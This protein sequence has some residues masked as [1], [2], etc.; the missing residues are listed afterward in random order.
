[1]IDCTGDGDIAARAGAPFMSPAATGDRMPM[2]LMYRLG[3]VP[4]SVEGA[5]GG[6]RIGDRVV[7]WGPGFG[8]D[9]LDVENL[10]RAEVETRLKLWD[11]SSGRCARSPAWNRSI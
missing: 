6:I 8:G 1:M 9:G 4:A 10:T 5:F 2:S 11:D 3:G 7:K